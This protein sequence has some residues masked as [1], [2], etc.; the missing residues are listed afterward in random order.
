MLNVSHGLI[1]IPF[2]VEPGDI[3]LSQYD[4]MKWCVQIILLWETLPSRCS[5]SARVDSSSLQ[6]VVASRG[7]S[8]E[9]KYVIHKFLNGQETGKTL[10]GTVGILRYN[11]GVLG[12]SVLSVQR[13]VCVWTLVFYLSMAGACPLVLMKS[14]QIRLYAQARGANL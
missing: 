10:D 8:R 5:D 9:F 12:N 6:T 13:R 2:P 11:T 7:L 14:L 4:C 3:W 1:K